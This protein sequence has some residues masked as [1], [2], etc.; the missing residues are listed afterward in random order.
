VTCILNDYDAHELFARQVEALVGER[1]V[2]VA[3]TT[4]GRSENVVRGLAAARRRG[5]TTLLFSGGDGGPAREHATIAVVVPSTSTARVQEMHVLL[6]HQ[7]VEHVD[8]WA[9]GEPGELG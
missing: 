9:A 5:A 2:A 3:F 4:S 6:M 8:A 7:L 1:D